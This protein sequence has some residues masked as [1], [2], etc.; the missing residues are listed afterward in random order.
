MCVLVIEASAILLPV[1]DPS[2]NVKLLKASGR[3]GGIRWPVGNLRS[4]QGAVSN[5]LASDGSVSNLAACNST[6]LHKFR[7]DCAGFD[8]PRTDAGNLQVMGK[9][10]TL[11]QL[12][13][14]YGPGCN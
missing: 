14:F 2:A 1:T 12:P 13:R 3:D 9:N 8:M 4:S 7:C 5:V 6:V 11:R 10:G